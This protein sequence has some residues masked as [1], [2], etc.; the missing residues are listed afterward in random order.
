[1]NDVS[2][3][4]FSAA[5]HAYIMDGRSARVLADEFETTAAT[6]LRW[7]VGTVKPSK[8]VRRLVVAWIKST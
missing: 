3:E 7:S 1:M 8:S 2:P 5:V 6:V 4:E